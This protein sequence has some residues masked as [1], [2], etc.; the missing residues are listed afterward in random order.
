[1]MKIL[2]IEDDPLIAEDLALCISDM[3]YEVVGKA[4]TA[5][6]AL[7]KIKNLRPELILLDIELSGEM[8]GIEVAE[9]INL[10]YRI[11]FIYVTS[12]FDDNTVAKAKETGPSG[13]ILKPF[14]E[15]DIKVAIALSSGKKPISKK[16]DSNLYV[17]VG[18]KLES[19]KVEEIEYIR[20]DDNYCQLHLAKKKF[21]VHQTL[22]DLKS[23][24][25]PSGFIQCH[26]SYLVQISSITCINED[27][28]YLSEDKIPIGK[29]FRQDLMSHLRIV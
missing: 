8:D 6:S 15:H 21:T 26:R 10:K 11:P 20:A 19:V 27:Y 1:M 24:L 13:Y 22:K 17:R 7:H 29:S 14:D 28:A 3:G 4:F 9:I 23:Q 16:E 5:E 12:F 25:T 2:I 18:S